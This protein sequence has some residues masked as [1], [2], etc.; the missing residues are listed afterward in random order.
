MNP[1]NSM[2]KRLL[3]TGGL[4]AVLLAAIVLILVFWYQSLSAEEAGLASVTGESQSTSLPVSKPEESSSS[5]TGSSSFAGS[6]SAP[7]SLSLIHIFVK[8]F[9]FLRQ[10]LLHIIHTLSIRFSFSS[11]RIKTEMDGGE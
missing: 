3:L 8:I 7:E 5:P 1:G 11:V 2:R 9:P 10:S 4:I 6:S